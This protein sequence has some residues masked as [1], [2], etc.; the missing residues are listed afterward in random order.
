MNFDEIYEK[1][2]TAVTLE[3]KH[4]YIDF[5]GRKMNFSK[6][7]TK[8]LYEVL[9]RIYK[10]EKQNIVLL[11]NLFEAYHIDSVQNRKYT[12]DKTLETFAHLRKIIKPKNVIQKEKIEFKEEINEIDVT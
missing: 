2:K 5:D 6:F 8:T 4:Q 7:M 10:S 1:V 12:I 11:L 9:N 3:V